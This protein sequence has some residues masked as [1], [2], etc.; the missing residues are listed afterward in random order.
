MPEKIYNFQNEKQNNGRE[1]QFT[2]ESLAFEARLRYYYYSFCRLLLPHT[3]EM[4]VGENVI[5]EEIIRI[6]ISIK[7][8]THV[9]KSWKATE[10]IARPTAKNFHADNR[11]LA[12]RDLK[13]RFN[14][15]GVGRGGGIR[16]KYSY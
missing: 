2:L 14:G 5:H 7:T 9:R 13:K 3:F 16:I 11:S 1:K 4:N 8:Y 12:C 10:A 6:R 15:V